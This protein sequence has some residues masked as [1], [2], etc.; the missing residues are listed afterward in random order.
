MVTF[1]VE[2]IAA[3]SEDFIPPLYTNS[4]TLAALELCQGMKTLL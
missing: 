1:S 4:L 3:G 2:I